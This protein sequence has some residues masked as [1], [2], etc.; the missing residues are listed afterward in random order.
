MPVYDAAPYSPPC[1]FRGP[2]WE[3]ILPNIER[4]RFWIRYERERLELSDGD[5]VDL[6]ISKTTAHEISDTCIV[7]LHGLEGSSTAPYVKSLVTAGNC[8][9]YDIVAMNMRGCSGEMN[10]L[11]RFYHSGETEDL[12]E[13]ILYLSL[14]YKRIALIGFS[15]GAN[16]VLKYVGENPQRVPNG[17]FGAVAYSAPIDLAASARRISEYAN[18]FYMKRFIRLLSVKIEEKARVHPDIINPSGCRD[19]TSFEEFDGTFTAPL[20][21]Y[22]SAEDYWSRCS[23]NNWLDNIRV[24]TLIVNAKNDPFLSASCFPTVAVAKNASLYSVF[25]E[26]GGHMGFPSW[27]KNG[28]CWH[29]KTALD[30]LDGFKLSAAVAL[31]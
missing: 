1:F 7:A 6:D 17:V 8:R 5:F 9:G 2:H 4:R 26:S 24:P 22:A 18:S 13:T 31:R 21:G 27:R 29:E 25:P 20:N 16:V 28:A 19:M 23:S 15:L 11:P 3:T 14:R 30:F 12:H 10:R